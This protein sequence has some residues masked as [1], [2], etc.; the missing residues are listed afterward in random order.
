MFAQTR[1]IHYYVCL[2]AASG[3]ECKVFMNI[4]QLQYFVDLSETLNFTKTAQNFYISQT[5][6]TKQIQCLEGDLDIPLFHRSKKSVSLTSE[7]QAY[8]PYAKKI[9]EDIDLSYKVIEEYRRG[10]RCTFSIG[11]IKS[12][13]DELLLNLLQK[14]KENYPLIHLQ[15]QAYSRLELLHL[16]KERKLDAIITFE[17]PEIKDENHLLL[18]KGHLRKYYHQDCSL[19]NLK[20][21]YD[22]RQESLENYEIEQTLLKVCLKEG[23]AI[24]HDFIESNQYSKYLQYQDLDISSPISFYYHLNSTNKIL[25]NIIQL[26]KK[27]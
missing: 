3:K 13:D 20:L 15:Y 10:K 8:L 9:L 21:I 23:Y 16:F 24:L 26:I 18:K 5:A 25:Q 1:I 12:L 6:I 2:G 27:G 11:F 19:N 14:I 17:Y 7:G 22:V 4:R